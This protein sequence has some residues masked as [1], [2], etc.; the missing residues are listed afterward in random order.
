MTLSDT[1][2]GA[3]IYYTTDGTTP[4]TASTRYGSPLT[5][6]STE[7]IEAIAITSGYANSA[8]AIRYIHDQHKLL[9]ERRDNKR[10]RQHHRR[11]LCGRSLLPDLQLQQRQSTGF[12][13]TGGAVAAAFVYDWGRTTL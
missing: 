7:T 8:V 13:V 11:S 9:P 12:S 3:A 6:N 4:T 2:P 5:V 10:Q 1:T